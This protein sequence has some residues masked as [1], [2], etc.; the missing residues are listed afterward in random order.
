MARLFDGGKHCKQSREVCA[1]A[2]AGCDT[3]VE[4]SASHQTH[5][6]VWN[7]H[8]QTNKIQEVAVF[9]TLDTSQGKPRGNKE[10][11]R[12][13]LFSGPASSF[14]PSLTAGRVRDRS[15][16]WGLLELSPGEPQQP[17]AAEQNAE[18]RELPGENPKICREALLSIQQRTDQHLCVRPPRPREE[19]PGGPAGAACPGSHKARPSHQPDWKCQGHWAASSGRPWLSS[20][21]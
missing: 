12:L 9:K 21:E 1:V 14:E 5:P 3:T 20:G 17:E 19:P 18:K 15:G 6:P 4:T 8:L 13:V 2:S 7:H 10:Q 16:T 11:S